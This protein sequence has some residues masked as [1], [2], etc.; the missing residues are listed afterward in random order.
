MAAT[1]ET[2]S[3]PAAMT[4]EDFAAVLES[5]G[6]GATAAGRLLGVNRRTVIRWL[7][8]TTPISEPNALLVR[9]RTKN[10]KQHL[11]KCHK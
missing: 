2:K 1:S 11:T 3:R 10:R 4:K 9:H 8:G 5:L 7:N 6:L